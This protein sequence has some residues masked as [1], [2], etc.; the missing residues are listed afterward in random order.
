[1]DKIQESFIENLTIA[2]RKIPLFAQI[3]NLLGY[4]VEVYRAKIALKSATGNER[5]SL[6]ERQRGNL[7]ER[8]QNLTIGILI[9]ITNCVLLII[10]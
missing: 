7:G 5:S 8:R 10:F 1:M 6:S 9:R 3:N 4:S 2:L